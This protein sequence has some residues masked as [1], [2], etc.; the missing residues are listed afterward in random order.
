LQCE[1]V[2]RLLRLLGQTVLWWQLTGAR[3]ARDSGTLHST[4]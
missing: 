4:Q 2:V 3:P 1:V